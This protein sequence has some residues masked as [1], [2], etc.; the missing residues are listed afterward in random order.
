L[1]K[2]AGLVAIWPDMLYLAIFAAV[3]L[4]IAVPLFKRTL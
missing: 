2:E 1:L 3:T 4:G